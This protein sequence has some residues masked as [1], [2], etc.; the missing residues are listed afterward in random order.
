[1]GRFCDHIT[2]ALVGLHWS[3]VPVQVQGGRATRLS[4]TLLRYIKPLVRIADIPGLRTFRSA[5]TDRLAVPSV[6]LHTIGNRAFP[7]AAPKVWNSLPH[8]I[9]SSAS[10][11]TFSRLLKTFV[12]CFVL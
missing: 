10:L 11:S 7:V 1:M 3:R 2:D 12:W 8:D 9:L 4:T 6:R 5:V